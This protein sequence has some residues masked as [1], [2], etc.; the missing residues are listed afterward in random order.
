MSNWPRSP[1]TLADHVRPRPCAA[2]RGQRT[3]RSAGLPMALAS[4]RSSRREE[5][6]PPD[7]AQSTLPSPIFSAQGLDAVLH[8]G[9]HLPVAR[10]SR[11]RCT[12]KLCKIWVPFSVCR[13]SGWNC[14][15]Y[16]P[17]GLILG[18]GHRAVGGVSHNLKAGGGA[19]RY[20]R[21]GSSSRRF[22]PAGRRTTGWWCPGRPRSCRTRAQ[23]RLQTLP[24]SMCIISWLP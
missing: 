5:S 24:P 13:T 18:S 20:S 19:S 8:E 6:T 4:M 23:G 1:N 17:L 16:R 21:Y 11:R 2:G 14:T 15:Q 22:C 9:V 7:R 12:A 3:C 10:H